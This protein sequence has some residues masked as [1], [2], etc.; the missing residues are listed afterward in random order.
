MCVRTYVPVSVDVCVG[1]A[2]VCP[3]LGARVRGSR[4]TSNVSKC[5]NSKSITPLETSGNTEVGGIIDESKR[6]EILKLES[7]VHT[8]QLV[9]CDVSYCESDVNIIL[10]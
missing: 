10:M 1:C 2:Y 4:A 3:P 9:N 6:L 7:N 8:S 5:S